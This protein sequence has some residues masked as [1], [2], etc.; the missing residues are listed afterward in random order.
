MAAFQSED[1]SSILKEMD[2]LPVT[3]RLLDPPLHEFLPHSH[4]EMQSLADTVGKPLSVVKDRV[5]QLQEVNPMLG[6]R[7]CRL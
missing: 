5:A 4:E 6:F 3:M 1:I 2:G 7:G